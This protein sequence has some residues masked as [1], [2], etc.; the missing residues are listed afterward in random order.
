MQLLQRKLGIIDSSAIVVGSVIGTGVF[1]KTAVMAQDA[2]TPGFVLL[3]WILAGVMSLAGALTYAEITCFFPNAGGEYVF[4]REGYGPALAFLYG[5]TRFWIVT[6]GSIAAYAMGAASFLTGSLALSVG[7]QSV[8]ALALIVLFTLINCLAVSFGGGIQA[9]M[10]TLKLMLIIGLICGLLFMAPIKAIAAA[11]EFH[12]W[13]RFG[14]AV[15]AALWAFDGWNN[16]PMVA[17]EIKNPARSIPWSLV[18]GMCLVLLIYVAANYAYFYALPFTEVLNANSTLYPESLPVATKA[19]QTLIGTQAI[20]ILS[21]A[22]VFSAVG[23]MNGSILTGA[24]VPYAMASDGLFFK[25]LAQVNPKSHVPV[26][27]V[28]IQ[29]LWACP[30]ALSGTFDQITDCVVFTSWIFYSLVGFSLFR[31]RAQ[32]KKTVYQTPGYPL[33]PILFV[34]TSIVLLL[35]TLITSPKQSLLG[36]GFVSLGYPFYLIYKKQR[37]PPQK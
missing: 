18:G 20:Q 13:S 10:T 27:A 11:G 5:W 25:R 36:M 24:R 9:F 26:T 23:A 3:A 15:L 33:T 37:P 17:G 2:G 6:P 34:F 12:G 4:L 19:A 31:F 21:L 16:L 28:V 14:L 7:G 35:N 32:G 22:F 30:I 1:L 29:G 8:I